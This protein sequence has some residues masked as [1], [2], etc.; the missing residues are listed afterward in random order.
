LRR[1]PEVGLGTQVGL[2][3][4]MKPKREGGFKSEM[5]LGPEVGLEPEVG[6]TAEIT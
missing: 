4:E 6:P 5:R 3:P 2:K 1:R